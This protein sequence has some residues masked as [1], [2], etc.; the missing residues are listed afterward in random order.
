MTFSLQSIRA[1]SAHR[2]AGYYEDVI[3]SGVIE[4]DHLVLSEEAYARL[5]VKYSPGAATQAMT[6]ASA[7]AEWLAAGRPTVDAAT[8]FERSANCSLCSLWD[9]RHARCLHCGCR[10][11]K[12]TWST[13]ACPL[14]KWP[15]VTPYRT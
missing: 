14:G 8:H 5:A 15:A 11:I 2:P 10:A 6:F 9:A 12:L 7:L 1:Q 13:S 4:G 3:A